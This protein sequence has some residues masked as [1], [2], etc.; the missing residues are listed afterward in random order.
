MHAS[1]IRTLTLLGSTLLACASLHAHAAAGSFEINQD[2]AAAGCFSGDSPGFPVT[3]TV[4]GRYELSS[5]MKVTGGTSVN[6]IEIQTS[7]VDLDL[8]GHTLGA[9]GSCSGTPV[10]SCSGSQ[11]GR[12][13]YIS[14]NGVISVHVHNG[15]I[16]GFSDSAV[17]AFGIESGTLFD[18][19]MV[20]ENQF[21]ILLV[22][23]SSKTTIWIDQSAFAR[24]GGQALGIAN[25]IYAHLRVTNSTFSGNRLEGVSAG[26]G[27]T[28]TDNTFN[29]NGGV[30]IIC[31]PTAS[32]VC[33]IGRNSFVGNNGGGAA[34]Q[35]SIHTVRDMS[36]NACLDDGNCP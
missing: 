36:G 28:F 18:H 29:E 1:I 19:L 17:V 16:T 32:A 20:A 7:Q 35:F 9:G 26:D 6:G 24:N 2:C 4:P 23:A 30:A 13:I 12:G 31:Y 25:N 33:A 15:A 5:D 27:S 10:T 8:N 14:G 11:G 34:A 22:G 21:G 3:I